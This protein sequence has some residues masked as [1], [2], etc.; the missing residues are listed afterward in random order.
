MEEKDKKQ[1]GQIAVVE[2]QAINLVGNP[3]DRLGQANE[4]AKALMSVAQPVSI[5]GKPYL[6]IKDWQTIG[7]FYGLF[8]GADEAEPVNIDNVTGFRAKAVVRTADGTIISSAMAYCLDEGVWKGREKFAQASMAQTRAA[9]KAL[10]NCVGWVAH[11]AGYQDTPAEE[12]DFQDK[13]ITQDYV[14]NVVTQNTPETPKND[15]VCPECDGVVVDKR[16]WEDGEWTRQT[17]PKGK[18][19]PAFQCIDNDDFKNPTCKGVIWDVPE[20]ALQRPPD[21]LVDDENL[22][23]A[24]RMAQDAEDIPF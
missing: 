14:A 16:V 19:F 4:A 17:S 13:G 20:N 6:T 5:Q 15:L 9:S 11:L 10:R 2:S 3:Q 22:A 18:K 7:S 12:M 8:A 24:E 23:E 1:N 21:V